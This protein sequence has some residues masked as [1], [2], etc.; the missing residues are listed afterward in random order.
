MN[1][2]KLHKLKNVSPSQ[3][4]KF[5]SAP[6]AWACEKL[7]N[8]RFPAS[9]PL[10]QGSAVELGVE[11]GVF[12]KD[13]KIDDCVRVA[14]NYFKKNTMLMK[15]VAEEREKRT[16]IITRMVQAGIEQLRPLG[17]PSDPPEGSRQH[18]VKIPVR[19]AKGNDGTIDC[20]GYLDFYYPDL[21]LIV[22]LKTSKNAPRG[23]SLAHGIQASI[24]QRAIASTTGTVPEVKFLYVLSRQKDPWLWLD[25]EDSSYFLESFKQTV[26]QMEKFLRLSSNAQDLIAALPYDPDSF[27]WNDAQEI[28]T[29]F[30]G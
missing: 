7:G 4:A 17:V 10:I 27:Y 9:Y 19:F 2:F 30:Y 21:N 20:L 3:V 25:L 13:V 22:D 24:Y 5:R 23:W 14:I 26:C 29:K 15:D 28:A 12:N 6:S 18:Q 8:V 1:G 11:F 16:P